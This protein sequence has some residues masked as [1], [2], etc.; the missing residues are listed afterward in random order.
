MLSCSDRFKAEFGQTYLVNLKLRE[1]QTEAHFAS[2]FSGYLERKLRARLRTRDLVDDI[3]QET[4]ARVLEAIYTKEDLKTPERFG[5]FVNS[6]CNNVLLEYWRRQ[7]MAGD[8]LELGE[9]VATHRSPESTA[10]LSQDIAELR[11]ALLKLHK[12]DQDLL[13]MIYWEDRDRH[14]VSS[15]TQM[16]GN[17]VRVTLHRAKRA[18]RKQ[19]EKPSSVSTSEGLRLASCRFFTDSARLVLRDQ[20]QGQCVKAESE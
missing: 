19:L 18:V 16:S 3:R 1:P 5:A 13:R 12:R 11:K 20:S 10:E 7:R 17:H 2:Y 14:E 4:L 6:V 15:I 9:Q 8:T